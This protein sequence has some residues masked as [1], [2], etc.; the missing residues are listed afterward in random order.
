MWTHGEVK[1][2]GVVHVTSVKSKD[3]RVVAIDL[4]PP[5][6]QE[7]KIDIG[8]A[9]YFVN[10]IGEKHPDRETVPVISKEE[11]DSILAEIAASE[12]KAKAEYEGKPH[13]P[14]TEKKAKH[15]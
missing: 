3:G 11:R 6:T 5:Y 10:G 13:P 7:T 14:V 9:V 4:K 2:D 1:V 15:G 8:N 12:A